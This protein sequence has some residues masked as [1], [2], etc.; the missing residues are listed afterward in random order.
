VRTELAA[1]TR[2]S[3]P[4]RLLSTKRIRAQAII[5]A[6]C[7]WGVCIVDFASPGLFDRAGNIKFQDF[8]P[9][10]VSARLIAQHR[11]TELYDANVQADELHARIGES[12][13]VQI[14]D[15]YGSQVG[16][17]FVLLTNFSFPTAAKVLGRVKLASLFRLHLRGVEF[18]FGTPPIRRAGCDLSLILRCFTYLFADRFP[19][20]SWHVLPPPFSPCERDARGLPEWP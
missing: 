9:V 3:L 2:G 5:L 7:L 18:L 10:Y 15:V 4:E 16:R 17:L 6:V 12:T 19:S 8:L 1:P 14:P 11:A 20:C 13:R